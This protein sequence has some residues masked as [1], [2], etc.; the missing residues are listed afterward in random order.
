MAVRPKCKFKR[1][2]EGGEFDSEAPAREGL[3]SFHAPVFGPRSREEQSCANALGP[4]RCGDGDQKA[5]E[6]DLAFSLCSLCGGG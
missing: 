6:I 1:A 5:M 2:R 3:D 4:S